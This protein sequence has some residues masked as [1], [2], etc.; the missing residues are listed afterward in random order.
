M[1]VDI[2]RVKKSSSGGID[3]VT[4]V[5]PHGAEMFITAQPQLG[6]DP[7]ALF[8]GLKDI[9]DGHGFRIA[10]QYV[11]GSL[12]LHERGVAALNRAW[13]DHRWPVTWLEYNETTVHA[14]TGTQAFAVSG[15]APRPVEWNGRVVGSVYED[16]DAIYCNL[17]DL[18]FPETGLSRVEQAHRTFLLLE[19]VLETVGMGFNNVV[20]TWLY[21]DRLLEWYDDFNKVRHDF[22]EQRGVFDGLVPAS[23][24]IGAANK[25]GAALV[26]DALAIKPKTDNVRIEAVP[27]PLQCPA[28]EYG[29]AFSRAVE[30]SCPDCRKLLISGT[31]SIAPDGST[32][33]LDDVRSQIALTME[34]AEA[35]LHSRNM[36][37]RD[38]TR[39]VAYFKDISDAPL[40]SAYCVGRELERF[41]SALAHSHVCRDDLLFE[42]EIDAVKVD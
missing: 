19:E 17:G 32:V 25:A 20:R 2:T 3:T 22:F 23:T 13:P 33:H 1:Q 15:F 18:W 27:S 11:F 4:I 10:R 30:I 31:A 36:D 41:P 14:L 35:I 7:L 39:A 29:S 26:A 12:E 42:I 40:L 21:L 9:I 24:G 5:R 6:K 38:A 16:D 8:E 28:P 34:V 37:W